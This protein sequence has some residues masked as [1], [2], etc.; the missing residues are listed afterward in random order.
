MEACIPWIWLGTA[1][2]FALVEAYTWGLVSIWFAA[3][4]LLAMLSA[5]AGAALFWQMLIFAVGSL[6]ALV[7]TRPLVR[8]FVSSR[9]VPTNA[10]RLLDQHVKVTER[11]DPQTASGAVYADG[12]TWSAR[13]VREEMIPAGTEVRIL[14][15]EGVKLLVE[16]VQ[17]EE[18]TERNEREEE[19]V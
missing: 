8:R 16:P 18:R 5:M 4:A 6:A 15:I 7:V 12:K 2:V 14:R 9:T 11:I 19:N 10:D 13:S 3:G 17:S 1:V